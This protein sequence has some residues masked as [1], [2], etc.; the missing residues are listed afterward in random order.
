MEVIKHTFTLQAIDSI[1]LPSYKGS[2]FHGGLGHALKQISPTWFRY[3]YQPGSIS[4]PDRSQTL[5]DWPK[6][7]VLVPPLD[8]STQYPAG[9]HF[10]CELTLF[11]EATQHYALLHAAFETLGSQLGL[12][13]EQGHFRIVD[14]KTF[15]P[16]LELF[17]T[18]PHPLLNLNLNLHLLTR[19]RLK[20]NNRLCRQPPSFQLLMERLLGRLQTLDKAYGRGNRMDAELQQQLLQAA[21]QI[22]LVSSDAHWDDWDRFSGRQKKWMKF[23]GLQG[24]ICYSG[25]FS[26]F[27]AVSA[28]GGM[29]TLLG[30]KPVLG[31]GNM[32]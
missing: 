13:Y 6:P 12:G 29:D 25:D 23:G 7:F 4:S 8:D 14:V 21:A 2:A 9:H 17:P 10:Q 19:L 15:R 3:F 30:V 22:Q 32:N 26:A 31:W 5:T 27:I 18:T 24:N 28:I 20:T 16:S 1:V 11:G